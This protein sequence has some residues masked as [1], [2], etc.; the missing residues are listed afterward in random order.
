MIL[1]TGGAGFIGSHFILDWLSAGGEDVVNLD[2]LTYAGR[3]SNLA[4]LDGHPGHQFVHGDIADAGLV[5]GLLE[6]H[7]PRAIVHFAAH[8]HV[9][10]SIAAP[11]DFLQNNVV[12]T[13]WLL[14]AVRDWWSALDAIPRGAFRFLHVST[15][16]V[17]GS[18]DEAQPPLTEDAPTRP[19][20]PYAASK[21]AS[22]HFVRAAGKTW[23]LPVLTGHCTNNYGPHQHPEKLIPLAVSRAL[24]RLPIPLYGD[25]LQVRDWLHVQD[26]CAALRLMLERGEPGRAWNIAAA[27]PQ[28][29]VDVVQ[30]VCDLVDEL[31]PEPGAPKRRTLISPV[32]DRPGH[33][34]RYALDPA[35]IGRELGW[36]AQ[37]PFAQGLRDTVRWHLSMGRA[38]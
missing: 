17:F 26:H 15:D 19:N 3:L 4:A 35:R 8:T 6:R 14:E 38:A 34:R 12:G 32:A 28:R 25:G 20:N 37:R 9:D 7:Q 10:R 22:D 11:D 1:V 13:F 31:C 30:A 33:D 5:G 24:R 36:H 18:L 27:N 23:G 16:E 21:A 29:N 2:K